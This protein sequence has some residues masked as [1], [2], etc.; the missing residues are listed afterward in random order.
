MKTLNKEHQKLRLIPYLRR[1]QDERGRQERSLE[2]QKMEA[3]EY[4]SQNPEIELLPLMEESMTAKIPGRPVFNKVIELI[5]S[6]VADGILA[7]HPDRLARNSIDGGLIIYML[8]TGEIKDL[9]FVSWRFE[10]TPQGKYDLYS[11]FA[12]SKHFSDKLAVDVKRGLH[13]KAKEGIWPSFA[14]LGYKNNKG[15]KTIYVDKKRAPL[16]KMTF[17]IYGTGKYSLKKLRMT[18]SKLGLKSKTGKVLSIHHLQTLLKNPFYYGIMNY[19]G[20]YFEGTHRP[21]ISKKLFDQVQEVTNERKQW[22]NRKNLKYFLYR[23]LFRCGECGYS[24]TAMRKIKKSG[25]QYT[26]YLCT[27]EDPRYDC[28]QKKYTSECMITTQCME[29]VQ[30]VSIP[31]NWADWMVNELKIEKRKQAQDSGMLAHKSEGELKG[32]KRKP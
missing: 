20:E 3:I 15:R 28:T 12:R 27:R 21:L 18:M 16:I 29:A 11:A 4:A 2:D 24:I 8:D 23:G 22:K 10:N 13:R 9:K 26:Y 30:K 17:E 6:G 7:W 31:D 19:G 1:S 5:R 25:R 32:K 14:T